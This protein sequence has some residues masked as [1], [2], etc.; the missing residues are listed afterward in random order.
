MVDINDVARLTEHEGIGLLEIDSPPVNALGHAVRVGL[1][2]GLELA[3]ATDSIEA[4]VIACGGRTFFAG[5]DISEF[6][7]PFQSPDLPSVLGK[8]EAAGKIVVAAI[9]GTALGGGLEL[10]LSCHY[11]IAVPSAKLGLPEV[12]LGLLPGAGGTQRLPRI[13][14]VA[15]ALD[16][17]IS[18]KPIGTEKALSDGIIDEI[19]GEDRLRDDAIAYAR[20]LVEARATRRRAADLL[21]LPQ[22]REASAFLADYRARN[23]QPFKGFKAPQNIIL[24]V[25]AAA[26]LPFEAGLAREA[27]LFNE[28]LA[29]RESE[30]QRH[31][32]FA[33]RTAAK[34]PGLPSTLKPQCIGS[35]GV[36]GAGT[37][38]RG[39]AIAFL[40]ARLPV[41]LV[42]IDKG[43][44]EQAS[45]R[46][47]KTIAAS[48]EKGRISPAEA[49]KRVALLTT[50]TDMAA[51]GNADLVVEAVFERL[52][53]KLSIF[54]QL[55]AVAKPGAILAS[56]TSFLDLD[57]IAAATSRP[58]NVVGLH[59]FAPA[60]VMR[61]L[62]VV[63]G[64]KTSDAVLVTAMNLGRVLGKVAI[65][66]GV[67][68]GFIANRLM[69]RRGEA[70]D[71]IILEGVTPAQAD[72]AMVEFGFPM[73]VFSMMDLVGLD[74]VGWDRENSAGR[75]VQELLCE[76]GRWGQKKQGGYYDY[77]AQGRA[78]PSATV[79]QLISDFAA[80]HGIPQRQ[81]TQS[82][83]V[84]RLL[85]PVVNEGAKVLEEG[86]A[87][88]AS[89]IDMALVAG[90]AWPVFTGGPMFW[91]M[92]EGLENIVVRLR[93]RCEAGEAI[94]ISPLLERLATTGGSFFDL[95]PTDSGRS[96]KQ[97]A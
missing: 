13:A 77:D 34:I 54:A 96:L 50:S 70:A 92:S 1:E 94:Q 17:M 21:P 27:E 12:N 74:V 37:M 6:G 39:I 65:M 35:V 88:R 55:D 93:Q 41:T 84:E 49:E 76:A 10:A 32:F 56:N 19:A 7:K 40:N 24:A 9:H 44:L 91:G 63:R 4:V 80:R 2:Q 95:P 60:N 26:T 30:A 58:E 42:D 46:I 89:D 22:G 45:A 18:G 36:V 81:Y 86:I 33:E 43:A 20:R 57:A 68:D 48:V 82:E 38:G 52:D 79:E 31:I 51:L 71:R 23:P 78:A 67:C 14:G 5:A 85:D 62:E 16:M 47:A 61:L 11:R 25:E 73:G 72:A 28:L 83:I 69:A 90:Y 75:T 3:L 53:L 29:S 64:A 15:K 66:S 8:I 59:F 87:L 97:V